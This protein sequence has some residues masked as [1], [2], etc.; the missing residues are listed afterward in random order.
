LHL[1]IDF[2]SSLLDLSFLPSE[3]ESAHL[4]PTELDVGFSEYRDEAGDNAERA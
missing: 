2:F 4:L 3:P 1:H